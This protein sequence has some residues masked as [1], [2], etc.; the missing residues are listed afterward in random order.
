MKR[1]RADAGLTLLEVMI[2]VSLLSL[3]MVGLLASLR[4]GLN[5]LSKTNAHLI[6]NRRVIGTQRVLEEQLEGFMPVIA[7]YSSAGGGIPTDKMPFFEGAPESMRFVSTYSLQEAA[8]GLPRILEFQVIPGEGGKGV[9]LVVNENLYTGPASAGFFCLGRGPDPLTGMDGYRF[10]PIEAGPGSFVLADKL[11]FCRFS[12]LSNPLPPLPPEWM[13]GWTPG[14]P[15]GAQLRWPGAIRIEM[16]LLDPQ[17]SR[18]R[19]MTVTARIHINRQPMFE[20]VD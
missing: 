4:L 1:H 18:L 5:A 13:A 8:R 19:P 9:R 14:P 17:I 3:L 15:G 20:Y 12:F 2:A 7:L 10:R 16:G 11:Q 6:A